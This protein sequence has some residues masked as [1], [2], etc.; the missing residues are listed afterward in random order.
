ME[1]IMRQRLLPVLVLALGIASV[2]P[3]ADRIVLGKVFTDP[4]TAEAAAAARELIDKAASLANRLSEGKIEVLAEPSQGSS[5]T[6]STVLSLSASTPSVTITLASASD[7]SRTQSFTAITGISPEAP[8]ILARGIMLLWTS[9]RGSLDQGMQEPPTYVDELPAELIA[10]NS[11][12]M[13]ATVLPQGNLVVALGVSCVELDP[14]MRLVSRIATGLYDAGLYAYAYG[15]STTPAGTLFLKPGTGRDV[16]KLI[17]GAREPQRIGLGLD[18]VTATLLALPDGSLFYIDSMKKQALRIQGRQRTEFKVFTTQWSSI[19][20]TAIGP[21]GTIWMYDPLMKGIRIFT[22]EGTPVDFVLPLVNPDA[23]LSPYSLSVGPDGSFVIF[24]YGQV[25]RFR[26]DGSIAWRMTALKGAPQETLPASGTLCVDW[27]R[28]IIY[29]TD[30]MSRSIV[31]LIDRAWCREKGIRNDFDEKVIALRAKQG[32]DELASLLGTAKLYE[33]VGSTL[34]AKAYW[35]GVDDADPGNEEAA[36]R[37]SAIEIEELKA[38]AKDLDAKART[39]FGSIGVESARPISIQAIQKYEVI[40]SKS[41]GDPEVTKAMSDL[42]ELFSDKGQG[43]E[44]KK[45]ITITEV[46]IA[47]LFPSLMQWYTTHPAGVV[48]LKNTLSEPVEKVRAVLTIPR[49]M[50]LPTETKAIGKLGP[51][52]SASFDLLPALS[53]QVL[54]L[55]EDMGIQARVEILYSAGG[56]EQ[57]V[58]RTVNVTLYRNT[59]LTWNDTRKISSYITPNED[60]VSGFAARVVSSAGQ[61]QTIPL[62]R[63]LFQAMRIC[64]ALGAYGITYIQDPESPFSAALGK[65]EVVDTVRFPRTTLYNRTGDCDDTTAL[66]ASLLE[67]VGIRTAILTSPGHIFMAFDSGEPAENAAFLTATGLEV[68]ARNGAAW[69]P[70]ETTVLG[71]GFMGAWKS[72]SELVKKYSGAG[73]F[74]FIPLAGMRDAYP[75]LPLP[76]SPITV[77]EPARA[78]VE[79]AY[80]VSMTGFTASLYTTKLADLQSKLTGL[81]GRQAVK[82][83]V[84]E[85]ILHAMFG[86]MGDAENDFRKAITDDPSFISPYVNLANVRLLAKDPDGALKTVKLGLAQNADSALL[87]LLAARIYADR[88]D[89]GNTSVY[90]AKVKLAAPELAARY[91]ELASVA[92]TQRAA[93]QGEASPMIW[94]ADQ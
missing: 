93:Q 21:D 59:A 6:L 70:V 94:G 35:R 41:P 7:E 54:S 63:K 87:N 82:T 69:I 23:P 26:R 10:P 9:L 89:S 79:K 60:T 39:T 40:L 32:A 74:E 68:L 56:V 91:P 64:D 61:G 4:Q 42:K 14:T 43:T 73:P 25:A 12:P 76:S 3:A 45:P 50:D 80:A 84:Q 37:I 49:Y 83:R 85:G 13:G 53:A 78:T 15:V 34:M 66:L 55:Q 20:A 90:Y 46:R 31:K 47:N 88:N 2:L 24:S 30:A 44:K 28:G 58:A 48:T 65:T 36:A 57:S 77:S 67:S 18:L 86:R 5:Y 62:S 51:G 92:G 27:S 1:G 8:A 22:A 52:E 17:Q 29:L 11:F 16:Y 75:A 71:S 38:A 33:S 19:S 72:A 81:S